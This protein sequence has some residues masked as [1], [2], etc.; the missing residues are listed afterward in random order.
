MFH[1]ELVTIK[2]DGAVDVFYGDG[3]LLDRGE[4]KR[5]GKSHLLMPPIF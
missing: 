3:D 5:S 2:R 4:A 1:S